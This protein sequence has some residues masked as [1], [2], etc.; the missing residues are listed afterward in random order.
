MY[1]CMYVCM[2]V[3]LYVCMY[4]FMHACMHVF[5]YTYMYIVL[6]LRGK[7][8]PFEGEKRLKFFRLPRPGKPRTPHL[9]RGRPEAPRGW[10]S[11]QARLLSVYMTP[12][13]QTPNTFKHRPEAPRGWSSAQERERKHDT[14]L[15]GKGDEDNEEENAKV[16]DIIDALDDC[17]DQNANTRMCARGLQHLDEV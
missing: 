12:H 5:M 6:L 11:A 8:A 2:Y 1:A 16:D 4:V 13:L 7:E 3:C 15:P 14:K 10:S 9:P 17:C